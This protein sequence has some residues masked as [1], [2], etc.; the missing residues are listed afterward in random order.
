MPRTE[1]LL[2][3]Q[4][5]NGLYTSALLESIRIPNINIL[6]VFQNVRVIVS[7]ESDG[8]QIPWESTSLTGDFIF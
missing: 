7:E 5:K 8:R 6:Q 2:R 4:R 1:A 3:W